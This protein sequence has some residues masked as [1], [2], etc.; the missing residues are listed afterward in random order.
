[1]LF[2]RV[3]RADTVAAEAAKGA[4]STSGVVGLSDQLVKVQMCL[5]PGTFVSFTP[6]ANVTLT[7]TNVKPFL[8]ASA[9]DALWKASGLLDLKIN[10]A[11]RTLAD[12]YVLYFSGACGLAATPG[13]SNHETGKAVDLENWSAATSAMTAAGCTHTYPSTDPVH[14][15]CPG[16]DDRASSIKA[17]QHLWNVNNPTDKLVEDGSYGTETASRLAKS[18]AGGFPDPADC[19]TPKTPD[20][21]AEF[22]DQSFPKA[23]V[24]GILTMTEGADA[25]GWIELKN[26][27]AKAWDDKTFLATTMPRDRASAFVAPSW[28]SDHRLA[29]ATAAVAPGAT[30]K[31][32]FTL[33][34]PGKPGDYDEHLGVVEE[35]IAWF[36]DPDQGGPPDGVLEIKIKVVAT[37]DAGTDGGTFDGSS[38][39]G[40][41]GEVGDDEG[42]AAAVA[43]CGCRTAQLRGSPSEMVLALA[44]LVAV[45]GRRRART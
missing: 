6:H 24:G 41:G 20:W 25:T 32:S 36:S 5:S 8:L 29:N 40:D 28:T 39:G 35:G 12:Q 1:M 26:V 22:V 30:H 16:I 4:C 15:D 17:F 37:T 11:F 9:R 18:P 44:A 10:S 21:A 2:A 45:C 27:G 23:G 31:F 34:A 13:N 19:A 7:S 14:F 38:D 3:T 33:H 42:A 43:G